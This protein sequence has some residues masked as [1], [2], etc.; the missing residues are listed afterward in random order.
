MARV[1][2]VPVKRAVSSPKAADKPKRKRRE[3]PGTKAI[4][5]IRRLQKSVELLL[6][7]APLYRFMND[8]IRAETHGD[9]P[10]RMEREAR[11]MLHHEVEAMLNDV[12]VEAQTLA[13]MN[14]LR[15]GTTP[16][17]RHVK[18]AAY[19]VTKN[20]DFLEREPKDTAAADPAQDDDDDDDEDFVAADDASDDDDVPDVPPA[21]VTPKRKKK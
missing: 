6:P 11:E 20:F 17:P 21:P 19:I 7:R 3:K 18:H 2:T 9:K 1:K 4:R 14:G 12:F 8:I 15:A 13:G 10:L 5:E 16:M